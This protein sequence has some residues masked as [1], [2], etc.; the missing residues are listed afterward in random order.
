[1][2]RALAELPVGWDRRDLEFLT[3]QPATFTD[4]G[5]VHLSYVGTLLPAGFET[6]RAVFAAVAGLRA[7]GRTASRLRLHFFG[8]SNQRTANAPARVLPV[9]AEFGLLDVVTEQAPRLD[10]LTPWR[11]CAIR[12][13]CC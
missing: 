7:N 9:A 12:R 3:S 10:Y 2:T 5:L 8:T 13:P 6:L 4:D 11:C 1:M